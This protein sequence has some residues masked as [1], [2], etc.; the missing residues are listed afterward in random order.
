MVVGSKK[1]SEF[2][3][4]VVVDVVYE[5][6]NCGTLKVTEYL[7]ATKV[8]VKFINTG[9]ETFTRSECILKGQVKDPYHPSIHGIGFLGEG[10][11]R[12]YITRTKQSL[13]YSGWSNMLYRCYSPEAEIKNPTY[14]DCTVHKDWYNFQNYAEWFYTNYKEGYHVDKDLSC[15]G[16]KLYSEGTCIFIPRKVNNFL[17][18]EE[19]HKDGTLLGC[20][21][22]E[23]KDYYSAHVGNHNTGKLD[24]LGCYKNQNMCHMVYRIAKYTLA[25]N[26]SKELQV[27]GEL[28]IGNKL[29]SYYEPY[30]Y[31]NLDGV[32]TKNKKA[33]SYVENFHNLILHK[34]GGSYE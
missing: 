18:G 4:K 7:K 13:A 22:I 20:H 16:N 25:V 1:H 34:I 29:L 12:A 26:L 5:T 14:K 15:K 9:Y 8:K 30:A 17:S 27:K 21:R 24:F 33:I 11:Y 2:P 10:E 28:V 6:C 19:R 31:T 3:M 32:F 23:G